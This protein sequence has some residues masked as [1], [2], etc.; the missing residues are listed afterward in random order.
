MIR[1]RLWFRCSG[2]FNPVTPAI[3]RPALIGWKAK[4]RQ[5]DFAIERAFNGEELV[6]RMKGWV[7][8]DVKR[9][10]EV[11]KQR[12]FLKILDEQD[13]VVEMKTEEDF[14]NLASELKE[15][16]GGHIDLERI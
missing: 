12:A 16:F 10:V 4:D 6:L 14:E 11:V 5:I 9:V 1:A 3:F 8:A 7:T 13:L 15:E 2:A